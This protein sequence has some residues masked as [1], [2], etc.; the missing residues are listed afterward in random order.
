MAPFIR[1][2]LRYLAAFLVTKGILA[3]EIGDPLGADPDIVAVVEIAIGA[4]IAFGTEFY[5]W[6]ARRLGWRT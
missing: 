6:A 1:I 3:P 4:L 2:A 5:Y